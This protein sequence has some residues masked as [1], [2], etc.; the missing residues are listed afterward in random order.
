VPASN[1]TYSGLAPGLIGV[2]QLDILV[3][4]TVTAGISIPV[5]VSLSSVPASDPSSTLR[6]TISLQ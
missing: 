4:T 1:I 6:T 3:P 2:W 5:T